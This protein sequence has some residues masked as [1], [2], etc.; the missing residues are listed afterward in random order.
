MNPLAKAGAWL[1]RGYRTAVTAGD[2][3]R[4]GSKI[5]QNLSHRLPF[6]PRSRSPWLENDC[7]NAAHL[8]P[9]W[10]LVSNYEH[11]IRHF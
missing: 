11:F 2:P 5:E 7:I 9:P 8:L 6:S 1:L 4:R 3:G 10:G